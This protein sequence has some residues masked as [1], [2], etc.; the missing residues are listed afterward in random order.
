MML[1]VDTWLMNTHKIST[2]VGHVYKRMLSASRVLCHKMNVTLLIQVCLGW[3]TNDWKKGKVL[4][5]SYSSDSPASEG[6][7]QHPSRPKP[8]EYHLLY[9]IRADFVDVVSFI[10]SFWASQP[11]RVSGAIS[12]HVPIAFIDLGETNGGSGRQGI[13]MAR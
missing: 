3:Q 5:T 1:A 7:T 11:G 6:Q 9:H 10:L 8:L 4:L 12:L 13:C 2:Y